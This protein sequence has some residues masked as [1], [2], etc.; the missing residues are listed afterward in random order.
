MSSRK[1]LTLTVDSELAEFIQHQPGTVDPSAFIM[2]LFHE[3][4]KK[5]GFQMSQQTKDA[6]DD[7]VIKELEASVDQSIPAAG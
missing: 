7:D 6:L 1:T 3:D 4:M 2:Q 5:Q